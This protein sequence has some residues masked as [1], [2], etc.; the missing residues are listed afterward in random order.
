MRFCCDCKRRWVCTKED[1]G[2]LTR[3]VPTPCYRRSGRGDCPLLGF[4][5]IGAD[6]TFLEAPLNEEEIRHY[7][8]EV[9]G[10]RMA[11]LI[12]FGKIPLPSPPPTQ[13]EATGYQITVYPLTL[14]QCAY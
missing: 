13:S 8:N 1:I 3:R 12:E 5:G 9:P 2:I 14:L 7:C 6:I 10:P 11:N 4:F